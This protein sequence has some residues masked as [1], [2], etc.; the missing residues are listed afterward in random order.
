MPG[1]DLAWTWPGPI[2]TRSHWLDA[3]L[4]AKAIRLTFN[5]EC[6]RLCLSVNNGGSASVSLV[7]FLPFET[8]QKNRS[9]K[10]KEYH[11]DQENK[12]SS[13]NGGKAMEKYG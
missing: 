12:L 7:L 3:Q 4:Q 9:S 10:K 11:S 8:A 2:V 13:R 1:L 5:Y 6:Q